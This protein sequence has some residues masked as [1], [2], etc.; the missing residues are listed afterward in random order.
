M[1]IDL[2]TEP[3]GTGT[4]GKPVYPEGHLAPTRRSPRLVRK[5]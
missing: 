4:D 2:T 3:L 5:S 1:N